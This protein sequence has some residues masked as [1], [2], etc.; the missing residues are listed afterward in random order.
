MLKNE[1]KNRMIF[2][3]IITPLSLLNG[4]LSDVSAGLDISSNTVVHDFDAVYFSQGIG[5]PVH[6]FCPL[7]KTA[8]LISAKVK[9][10]NEQVNAYKNLDLSKITSYR[11]G[12]YTYFKLDMNE[13]GI[14]GDYAT[15]RFNVSIT[16]RYS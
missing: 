15:H 4:N 1:Y 9:H 6:I 16:V 3:S 7:N 5:L 2:F 10:Y 13:I 11:Q 12:F 8:T 14:P